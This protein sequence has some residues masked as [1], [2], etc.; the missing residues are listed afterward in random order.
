MTVK[1]KIERFRF[2]VM[3]VL[4]EEAEKDSNKVFASESVF[5]NTQNFET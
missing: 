1:P 3:V 2:S 5:F 4:L